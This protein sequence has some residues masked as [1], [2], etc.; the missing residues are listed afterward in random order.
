MKSAFCTEASTSMCFVRS[1]PLT[2]PSLPSTGLQCPANSRYT[3]CVPL[4]PPSCS[5]PEGRCE[6]PGPTVPSVCKE[7]CLCHPGFLLDWDKCVPRIECG[8][9]DTHGALIPVSGGRGMGMAFF[10][11]ILHLLVCELTR[12]VRVC[13]AGLGM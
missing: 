4:C 12:D 13:I 9:K 1:A 7:G 2:A 6:G 3:D 8:C 10:F 11:F 5:D